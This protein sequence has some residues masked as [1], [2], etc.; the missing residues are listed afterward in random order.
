V[1]LLA[2][3]QDHGVAEPDHSRRIREW[4][5]AWQ[6]RGWPTGRDGQ[7]G[8][9]LYLLDTYPRTLYGDPPQLAALAGDVGWVIA[10]IQAL[11]VDAVLAE[12]RTAISNAPMN[13]GWRPCTPWCEARPT[14]CATRKRLPI[15]D[16][17]HASCACRRL[18]SA[19]T[20]SPPTAEP[21]SSPP[22]PLA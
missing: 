10:A 2:R 15:P 6:D 12:L 8:T 22:V 14:I 19:K 11:G 17:C 5:A 16:S 18:N 4:A 3:C 13:R 9:P 7:N 21:G 20:T 1:T